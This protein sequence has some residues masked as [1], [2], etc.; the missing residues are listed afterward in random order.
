MDARFKNRVWRG[1]ERAGKYA[2]RMSEIKLPVGAEMTELPAKI[3]KQLSIKLSDIMTWQVARESIDARDKLNIFMVYTLDFT[4]NSQIS[5]KTAK[6]HRCNVYKHIE[7]HAPISGNECLTGRPVVIGFGPC[8]IFA[9]LELSHNGYRPIV[10]ERGKTMSAR[11]K[12]VENFRQHGVLDGE[13]NIL[14]GEGGA[15]TFSDGKLTS[16]IKDPNIK[17]VLETFAGA[18]AGDEIVYKHKPHIGTDVLR[19][20]IVSLREQILDLGGDVRFGT[21]LTGLEIADGE[22]KG[23]TVM[24]SDGREEHIDTNAV[25]LATGHSARDTYELIKESALEMEQKPL[26]IGVR[27]EH[28]Q[29]L[30][31]RAQYGEEDRL[32]PAEYKVSYKASNG[33]GVY[34]FCMCPGGE[35]VVCSTADGELCV[36]GMSNRRRDSG[37]ANSG[38]LCDVRVSDFDSDDVLSGVKFQQKYERLAFEN[39]GGK[40]NPPTCTM[41]DFLDA[42]AQSVIASLPDFAYEAIREAI[43]FFAEKIHG[44]DDPDAVI[45]AVETRSSAPVR[46]LRDKD[47]G[48]STGISGIYPAGEGCGYAGGITSAACDGIKQ[49]DK[50]IERFGRPRG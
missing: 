27:M 8:G 18:G 26:S 16:G 10:I 47:S 14:F 50:L 48:E 21:R 37:V 33:R 12:D 38:I 29:E 40:F 9:A 1:G 45:K 42:N 22:L 11:V 15:G 20:V 4:T 30:I 25:I 2:Y 46:V 7:R 35:V 44:Y 13:S 41:K 43:P 32:P 28:S 49:A 24:D 39:G 34:S 5:S 3:A 17:F 6:K 19:A 31:N 36:N 23:I